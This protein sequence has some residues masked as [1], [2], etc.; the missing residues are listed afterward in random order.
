MCV[1]LV[2][3][4]RMHAV[5]RAYKYVIFIPFL[6]HQHQPIQRAPKSC[7]N[8]RN[9]SEKDGTAKTLPTHRRLSVSIIFACIS[10]LFH[11][12]GYSLTY[13][14]FVVV[15]CIV[16]FIRERFQ[17]ILGVQIKRVSLAARP[18]SVNLRF[19]C[20]SWR[21]K[22][23]CHFDSNWDLNFVLIWLIHFALILLFWVF[24]FVFII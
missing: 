7:T 2:L 14:E 12:I 22:K 4:K 11:K 17:A 19:Y 8:D 5:S 20:F 9:A 18:Q 13:S 3:C 24:F 1:L 16:A 23:K 6:E 10:C 21:I 15:D